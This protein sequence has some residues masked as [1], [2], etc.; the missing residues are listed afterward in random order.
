MA[1]ITDL[2]VIDDNNTGRWPENMAFSA[3]NNA[4]RA[5]EGILARWFK[6]TNGSL[7]ASGS[8]NAFTV[9]SNR[10][11]SSLVDGIVLTFK[12]N[13]NITGAAT[14]NL[15]G[16]GAKDIK[17]FN[18][19]ALA[20]GDII[21]GQPVQVMYSASLDDWIM[22]SALAALVG[23]LFGDF[24]EN[25]LPGDPAANTARIYA[26][27]DGSGRTIMA[28]RDSA[29]AVSQLLPGQIVQRAYAETVAE[30]VVSATIPVDNSIPQIT[31]GTEILTA[32]ITPR[33]TTNRVRVRF[34]GDGYTNIASGTPGIALFRDAVADA[35]AARS[36]AVVNG[37]GSALDDREIGWPLALEFE[38]SP[39]TVSVVTYRI[40][41]GGP[42]VINKPLYGGVSRTTLVLEEINVP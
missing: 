37:G 9:T 20:A 16:L 19:S 5:D 18:G 27:D 22:V 25:A 15:N 3:V 10:T 36:V 13:H 7:A 26:L 2:V 40:R 1:E 39:G 28:Y 21:S 42:F 12:A 29:G 30:F 24:G 17:R 35:L 14:L 11:I 32:S 6:D 8:S 38:H 34:I 4:G 41:V 31:E 33:K 23:S